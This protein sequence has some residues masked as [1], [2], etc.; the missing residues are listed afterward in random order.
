MKEENINNLIKN[1]DDTCKEF[2]GWV[3]CFF[4]SDSSLSSIEYF[5]FLIGVIGLILLLFFL[6][7]KCYTKCRKTKLKTNSKKTQIMIDQRFEIIQSICN[8]N[9]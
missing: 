1:Y 2:L 8:E 5:V 7:C 3:G 6:V 9:I 4:L